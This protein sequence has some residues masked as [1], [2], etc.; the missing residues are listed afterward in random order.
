[1]NTRALTIG[2]VTLLAAGLVPAAT[3]ALAADPPPPAVV[4]ELL[5]RGA[6]GE[7]DI[8]N[9]GQGVRLH[10]AEPTDLA[11]VKATLAPMRAT[12][13]HGHAGPSLVI[14]KSGTLTMRE[15]GHGQHGC[16]TEVIGAGKAFA[17]PADVHDFVN[18][19]TT[20]VEFYIAY[21]LPE[22]ASPAP[23]PVGVP[24]GCQ[25]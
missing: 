14:V 16:T 10:A 21:L 23:S 20:P 12:G 24:Q 1:M 7:L 6:G 2:V 17:H 4:S 22:G 19:T 9:T 8:K 18:E 5:A 15:A 13:W 11:L 25:P 3:V